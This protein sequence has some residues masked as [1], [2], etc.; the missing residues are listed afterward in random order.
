MSTWQSLSHNVV[1]F[2]RL[3]CG[4]IL[5]VK[6]TSLV[7]ILGLERCANSVRAT[8]RGPTGK[9]ITMRVAPFVVVV[10][11]VCGGGGG[12]VLLHDYRHTIFY[13]LSCT[14]LLLLTVSYSYS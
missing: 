7:A 5:S 14:V 12:G 6:K 11:F 10:V 4:K 3:S 9:Q 2:P 1:G 8:S 13:L